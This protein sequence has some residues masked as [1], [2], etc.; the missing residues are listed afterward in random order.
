MGDK[1]FREEPEKL[2]G[3]TVFPLRNLGNS[4]CFCYG[5]GLMSR[6]GLREPFRS[7]DNACSFYLILFGMEEKPLLAKEGNMCYPYFA[8]NL[9]L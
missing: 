1:L 5:H 8:A 4:I 7:E 2:S 6:Y 3:G 9:D